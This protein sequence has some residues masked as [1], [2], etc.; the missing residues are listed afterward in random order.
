MDVMVKVSGK[1]GHSSV[2]PEH[3]TIGQ[4]AQI[5]ELIE[6]SPWEPILTTK[7]RTAPTHVMLRYSFLWHPPMSCRAFDQHVLNFKEEYPP[8]RGR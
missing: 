4:L 3:T 2:P 6:K 7:S 5:I 1:G 8:S